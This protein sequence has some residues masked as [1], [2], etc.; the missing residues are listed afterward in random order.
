MADALL[1]P[2]AADDADADV[3]SDGNASVGELRDD[4]GAVSDSLLI[5]VN[6]DRAGLVRLHH[7]LSV[8]ADPQVV[9]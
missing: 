9:F 5:S 7:A 6:A 4:A 8:G 1:D 3:G 2:A